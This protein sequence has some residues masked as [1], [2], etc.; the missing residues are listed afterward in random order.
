M[1]AENIIAKLRSSF[2]DSDPCE[3]LKHAK[4]A[5]NDVLSKFF[6]YLN[7]KNEGE[8]SPADETNME[9]CIK[10]IRMIFHEIEVLIVILVNF[11]L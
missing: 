3:S 2:E 8:L 5:L 4:Q 6:Q 9:E 7:T 10:L 11:V 1:D